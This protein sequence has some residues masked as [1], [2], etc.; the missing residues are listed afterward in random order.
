MAVIGPHIRHIFFDLDH[1][2][3]DYDRNA[4]E[5]LDNLYVEFQLE[6]YGLFPFDNFLKAF[7]KANIRVW[8]EFEES[9]MN[10]FEL[11][12][13]RLELVFEEFG[14]KPVDIEGFNEA[15]YLQCSTGIHLV[16][17]ALELV[18][19]L[20]KNYPLHIITNGFEDIQYVKLEKTGLSPFFQTV[21]T[22]EKA[23]SKKPNPEYFYFALDLAHANRSESLIVGD[24]LRT[25][26]VGAKNSGLEVI[27]F[28]PDGKQSPYPEVPQIKH[29]LDLLG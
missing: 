21:T 22:S 23:A 29:L 19:R 16:D 2:L 17:G 5:T 10:Q 7:R 15:Y 12:H 11:R 28:N 20:S 25:D 18:S 1:T 8:D 4:T 26:V 13:K 24:G 14:L 3:W 6:S 27:W 9:N